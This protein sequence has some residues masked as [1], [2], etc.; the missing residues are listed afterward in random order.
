MSLTEWNVDKA[1]DEIANGGRYGAKRVMEA[2]YRNNIEVFRHWGYRLP[3]GRIVGLGDR[4]ALL[5]G[6]KVY[7]KPF[8]VNDVPV[9]AE[10]T[11]T[12][13]INADCVD[14][15]KA[16]LDSGL[17]PA[18]LNLA[19]RRRPGVGFAWGFRKDGGDSHRCLWLVPQPLGWRPLRNRRRR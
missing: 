16:M 4:N 6:T 5:N 11:K 8:D 13:C 7:A 14:V 15:A 17:R 19:S 9:L 2:V 12:G 1:K 3:D 18:I 10:P